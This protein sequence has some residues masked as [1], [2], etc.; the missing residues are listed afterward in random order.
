[1]K[2][3]ASAVLLL[4]S[5]PTFAAT[6]NVALSVPDMSCAACPITIKKVLSKI[7]GVIQIEVSAETRQALVT[8][9]DTKT[10]VQALT[11]A[12]ANVGF[13]SPVVEAAR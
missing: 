9:D 8:Y 7:D 13:P 6:Q 2:R 12:T 11:A 4:A 3:F 10:H 1:M 5:L